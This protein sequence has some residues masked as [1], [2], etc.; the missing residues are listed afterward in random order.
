VVYLTSELAAAKSDLEIRSSE[1]S[2]L[3]G[4][5]D[6]LRG[7]SSA[8]SSLNIAQCEQLE[9]QLRNSLEAVEARKVRE[10]LFSAFK[11]IYIYWY[12]LQAVLI[13]QEL[14][15]QKEQRLCVICQERDKCVVLLPCRHM[16][17]CE[18][19]SS[20]QLLDHCPLCRR[21]IAHKI[22]VFS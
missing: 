19:C 18:D 9:A 11:C 1:R 22:S 20:H 5:L 8:L 6:L 7:S 17:M 10:T 14:E 4:A 21:P 13:Q 16:C 12:A 15:A 3:V 2:Q